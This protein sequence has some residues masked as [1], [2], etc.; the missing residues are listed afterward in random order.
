MDMQLDVVLGLVGINVVLLMLL[1][2]RSISKSSHDDAAGIQKYLDE[3]LDRLERALRLEVTEASRDAR[4]EL[5]QNLATFQQ[6]QIQQLSLMQKSVGD[7]LH[8]QLQQ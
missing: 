7:T 8:Q 4:Q 2:W 1:V 5:T 3:K 6:S